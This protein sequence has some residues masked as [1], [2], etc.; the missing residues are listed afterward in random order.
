M[1]ITGT[2]LFV[3]SDVSCELGVC[4]TD[5]LDEGVAIP[6]VVG[7]EVRFGLGITAELPDINCCPAQSVLLLPEVRRSGEEE[8]HFPFWSLTATKLLSI[9][10]R[11]TV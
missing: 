9:F 10:A 11:E 5:G 4:V 8:P 1:G 6:L 3:P 7:F 2:L